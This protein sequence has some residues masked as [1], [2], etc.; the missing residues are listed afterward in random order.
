VYAATRW[1]QHCG[2]W[3]EQRRWFDFVLVLQ[4]NNL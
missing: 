1:G 2:D 4:D 3:E